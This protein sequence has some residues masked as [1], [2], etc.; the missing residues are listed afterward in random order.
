M[1][2]LLTDE[3]KMILDITRQIVDQR[4]IPVR[5]ELDET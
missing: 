3:Q 4:I 5:A 2:D 1:H